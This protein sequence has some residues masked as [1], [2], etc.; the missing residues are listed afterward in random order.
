MKNRCQESHKLH[1][2]YDFPEFLIIVKQRI[3][4]RSFQIFP[5]QI[6]KAWKF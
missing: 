4:E 5:L 1:D 2:I 3:K 6:V